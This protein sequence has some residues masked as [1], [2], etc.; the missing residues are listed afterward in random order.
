MLVLLGRDALTPVIYIHP[1]PIGR[2][3]DMSRRALYG[4]LPPNRRVYGLRN[5]G[6][7]KGCSTD[8]GDRCQYER[9]HFV[10]LQ[11]S[12]RRWSQPLRWGATGCEPSEVWL[13]QVKR[14]RAAPGAAC[15]S[16]RAR[17][18]SSAHDDRDAGC[19]VL[20]TPAPAR[21]ACDFRTSP[22]ARGSPEIAP[23]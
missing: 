8:R 1:I 11:Q 18:H 13:S 7:G 15:R 21:A 12:D 20:P 5:C 10:V 9:T 22:P 6:A 17:H 3:P 19:C 16:L 2:Q 23:F 14:C 4:R